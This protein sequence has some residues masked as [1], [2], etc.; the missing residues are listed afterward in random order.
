ME[1][2][3]LAIFASGSGSNAENIIRFFISHKYISVRLV[4]SNNKDA[5]V[6]E[7]ARQLNVKSISFSRDQLY[8]EDFILELLRKESISHVILAGFMWLIP[9]NL[10]KAFPNRML[11]I[12]PALLPKYGGK[13]MFG[14]HVHRAVIENKETESGISIHY[15]NESYD[16]GSII[17]KAKCPVLPYDTPEKL[18]ERIHKLEHKNYPR[19]IESV[20]MG[21]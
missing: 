18:A 5:F 21:T 3:N 19:V 1:K 12:H 17:F 15:V 2:S 9:E 4:L 13:G 6:H 7:R 8:N 14:M 20:I 10:I 11:N 16:E